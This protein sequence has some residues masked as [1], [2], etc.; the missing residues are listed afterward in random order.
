MTSATGPMPRPDRP[1]GE[2]GIIRRALEAA[3]DRDLLP[4]PPGAIVL[5]DDGTDGAHRPLEFTLELA[6]RLGAPVIV[7]QAWTIE[8]SLGELSDHHGYVR[9]F[10]EVTQA[11]RARLDVRRKPMI[12]QHSAV[13]VEFRVVLAPAA[14]ALVGLSRGAFLLVL[15]SRGLGA[16]GSLV[17]GSVAVQC[18]RRS[19]CPVLVVPHRRSG[20]AA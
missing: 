2:A 20:H 12:E 18:L 5:G 1:E 14:E 10:D 17:L 3:N 4:V 15:G 13:P 11:L 8:S 6:E 19:E 16:L 9:S 7:L